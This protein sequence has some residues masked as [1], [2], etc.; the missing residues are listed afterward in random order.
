MY[1]L[2]VLETERVPVFLLVKKI[3]C[4]R[5]MWLLCGTLLVPE[6]FHSVY[7]AYAVHN[8]CDWLVVKPVG[9]PYP[10]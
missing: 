6:A 9:G 7:H 8:D 2:C 3:V 5:N 10:A 4:I 1:V